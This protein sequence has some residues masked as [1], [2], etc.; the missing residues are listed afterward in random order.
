[1][2]RTPLC[3]T[4]LAT[5]LTSVPVSVPVAVAATRPVL[6]DVVYRH[7]TIYTADA[8][9]HV[10][11]AVAIRR[12][13][14]VFVG[15]DAGVQPFVSPT[16]HQVDLAGRA[17][18][19]GLIDGHMHPLEGGAKV[20]KCNL[21]YEPLTI[22]QMQSRI[23]A[24]LDATRNR[25][26]DG[27]L[28]V[29]SWFQ[30]GMLPAGTE[31]GRAMLD[32]LNTTRPVLVSNS[33]GHT[34]LANSRALALA[35]ITRTSPDPHDGRIARDAAGEPTGILEDAGSNSMTPLLPV[36]TPGENIAS[37]RRALA[38]IAEQGVTSFLDADAGVDSMAAFTAVAKQG[39]LTLR[40]HFAP[41]IMTAEAGN[42]KAAIARIVSLARRFDQGPLRASPSVTVRNAKL[43]L[44]GVYNNPAFTGAMVEPYF[45]NA[46]TATEARWQ[47]GT[48][49]GP[50]V[51]FKATALSALMIG[52]GRAGIDPHMHADG[53]RAVRAGLD[54]IAAMRRALPGADIRPGIVHAEVVTPADYGRFKAL[55]TFPVLSFQWEKPAADTV[56]QA[57]NYLGLERWRTLEPAG[58]L[59]AA[60]AEVA[61]GSDWPVD[62]L[63]EWFAL[64]VAVMRTN[65]AAAGPAYAGRL[66]DDPGLSPIQALRAATIVAARE[67]HEDRV[68]GSLEVGKFADL[69]VL[70][71][72]PLAIPG[73]QIAEVQ[74]LQ[75]VVGGHVVYEAPSMRR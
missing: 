15:G 14:I 40:A 46:G 11:E 38:D 26:P 51:Y 30:Q 75:T 10:V 59:L 33:F 5:T 20:L 36:A 19:P 32:A 28:E 63:D 16:T 64:K 42:P 68:T 73:E 72:N 35:G 50:D 74:V 49:R 47:P 2:L 7:G 44:D 8:A 53:D 4:L 3:F 62:R 58:V 9:D 52:L 48:Y 61:F 37:A 34:S 18:M 60:G 55:A 45:V 21:N 24:C 57:R 66:G 41:Q 31:T 6:A 56:D 13:L 17:A 67:L 69:I 70:D 43:F 23:Q 12:G 39:G 65:A 22:A 54:A 25:E 29:V 27:W 1:M 71:R